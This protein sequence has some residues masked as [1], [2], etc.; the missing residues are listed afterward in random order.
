MRPCVNIPITPGECHDCAKAVLRRIFHPP[1]TK[2][3]LTRVGQPLRT[4]AVIFVR[5]R[6]LMAERR[7]ESL[8]GRLYGD[9]D[10]AGRHARRGR[11]PT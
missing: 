9:G 3:C 1:Q 2:R 6:E 4:M 8:M 10:Q 5:K 11:L 7:A